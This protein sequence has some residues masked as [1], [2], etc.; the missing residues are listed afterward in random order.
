MQHAGVF[1]FR[2]SGKKTAMIPK[3]KASLKACF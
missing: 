1:F 3:E 2:I